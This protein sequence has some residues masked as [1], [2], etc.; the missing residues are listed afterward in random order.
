M[1]RDFNMVTALLAATVMSLGAGDPI[2]SYEDDY[3][4]YPT[5]RR[6]R[7]RVIHTSAPE[8]ISKRKARRLRGK[9]R[10]A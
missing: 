4:R 8:T 5:V 9:G 2:R 7:E 1:S 10:A 3:P 6:N